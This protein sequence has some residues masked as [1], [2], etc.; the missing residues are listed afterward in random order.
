MI[1]DRL[2]HVEPSTEVL[3]PS[4][5][6]AIEARKLAIQDVMV[7]IELKKQVLAGRL[8]VDYFEEAAVRQRLHWI[9][10]SLVQ[11]WR[12]FID[13]SLDAKLQAL[14]D[15]RYGGESWQSLIQCSPY[16]PFCRKPH[17]A[18]S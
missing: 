13:L 9:D 18:R 5:L 10:R 11:T 1:T 7:Q 6:V 14:N 12:S 4:T 3:S 2:F 16:Q 8:A 17:D 15:E